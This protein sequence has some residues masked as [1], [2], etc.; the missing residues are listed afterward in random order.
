MERKES[1]VGA[2][3]GGSFQEESWA[4]VRASTKLTQA[5]DESRKAAQSQI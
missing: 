1:E 3:M 2:D 5:M 4:E